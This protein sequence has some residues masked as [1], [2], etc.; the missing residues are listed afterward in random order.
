MG[1]AFKHSLQDDME[2]FYYVVFYASVLWLPHKDVP[3]IANRVSKFFDEYDEYD[4]KAQGGTAKESNRNSGSFYKLWLFKNDSLKKWLEAVRK[5]QWRTE[6]DEQPRWTPEALHDQWKSTDEEDLPI[7]D[8]VYHATQQEELQSSVAAVSSKPRPQKANVN[9]HSPSHAS[10]SV[11]I[12]SRTSSKRSA[13]D[14]RFE[15]SSDSSK[16]RRLSGCLV[17]DLV[18][19]QS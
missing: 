11:E 14:A 17:I 8:R 2:S 15:E 19:V 18:K 13:K 7:D 9:P 1:D 10:G 3:N 12:K 5:L 16:R 6:D 4:G